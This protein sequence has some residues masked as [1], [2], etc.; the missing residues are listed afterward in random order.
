MLAL[1]LQ[2]IGACPSSAAAEERTDGRTI[3]V[4]FR[5]AKGAVDGAVGLS[6]DRGDVKITVWLSGLDPMA[7]PTIH[8]YQESDCD[9]VDPARSEG[10]ELGAVEVQPGGNAW[11]GGLIDGAKL[12][13]GR[14]RS[15]LVVTETPG[16]E[17]PDRG[18]RGEIGCVEVPI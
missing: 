7:L 6:D 4:P 2:A 8:L 9:D 3:V 15:V 5:P 11:F 18:R 12:D 14:A 1:I 16:P 13:P 17:L 10:T